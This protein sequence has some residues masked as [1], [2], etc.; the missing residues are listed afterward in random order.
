VNCKRVR[1]LMRLMGIVPLGSKLRTGKPG[2]GYKIFPYLLRDVKIDG[3]N[4][5]VRR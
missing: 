4:Q 2:A 3:A 1:R 5:V